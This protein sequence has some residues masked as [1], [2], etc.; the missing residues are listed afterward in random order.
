MNPPS[1]R[2]RLVAALALGL[3][4]GA[5]AAVLVAPVPSATPASGP[6]PRPSVVSAA[7][8]AEPAPATALVLPGRLEG[9]EADAALDAFLALPV[10]ADKAPRAAIDERAARLRAL[11][12]LLPD[13]SLEKL[14]AALATRVGGAE[15]QIRRVAFE[16]W[17]ERDAP[18]AARWAAA[19]VPGEA[20]NEG[21][22]GRYLSIAAGAWADLDFDAAYAWA[23]TQETKTA[24]SL[25]AQLLSK[26][27]STQPDR[28]LALARARG[29][30]NY[31][32]MRDGIFR[33]WAEK[34]PAAALQ[35][36]G[37]EMMENGRMHWRLSEPWMK[38][39]KSDGDAAFAWALALPSEDMNRSL[40]NNMTWQVGQD[41]ELARSFASRLLAHPEV[42][43]QFGALR[44]LMPSWS[45]KNPAEALAWIKSIENTEHRADLLGHML[46]ISSLSAD[47]YLAAVRLLDSSAQRA[48]RIGNYI[49][50][51]AGHDPD[52]ALAWLEKQ[53][54]PEFAGAAERAQRIIIG[55]LAR[56]DPAAALARWQTLPAGEERSALVSSIAVGWAQQDPAAA[57]RWF[58]AQN[59]GPN[60]QNE[61]WQTRS[62]LLTC[63]SR[64]APDDY[65]KWASTLPDENSRMAAAQALANSYY[66]HYETTMPNELPYS[67][68]AALIAAIE[69]ENV[70]KNVLPNLLGNWLQR[71]YATARDWLETHE[72]LSDEKTAELLVKHDPDSATP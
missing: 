48:E 6:Q 37:H 16:I 31:A 19:I 51:W 21:A 41:P 57:A 15:A 50:T 60:R 55:Q 12:T 69:D 56:T 2:V 28:A 44:Q 3:A 42:N 29:E 45:Q 25:A 38:W 27:A 47:D 62:R 53:S 43:G 52:A 14:F 66:N 8:S 20:I 11:L 70:R 23:L 33:A 68:R 71:D 7:T 5:G 9:P 67:R 61:N 10:L 22:R 39:F 65:V 36:L 30:E 24:Q 40:L 64:T 1:S 35:S 13:S 72:V 49:S 46:D 17:T 18:A 32:A 26:L 54:G 4:I 34:H 58:E 59:T 63:Y